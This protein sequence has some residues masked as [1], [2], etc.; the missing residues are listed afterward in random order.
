MS[1][2]PAARDL[3]PWLERLEAQWVRLNAPIAG[4]LNAG[5]SDDAIDELAE[6]YGVVVPLELRTWWGWHDGAGPWP[7]VAAVNTV[8]IGPGGYEFLSLR[9]ALAK[10]EMNRRA[11]TPPDEF[12]WQASWLPFMTQGA[13]RLYVDCHE[14][15]ADQFSPV[16]LVSWE[17]DMPTVA[18]AWS[19]R[20][21]VSLWVWLLES[22]YYWW[23][24]DGGYWDHRPLPEF[25]YWTGLA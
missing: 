23:E 5:L 22:D 12:V 7:G 11:H 24:S 20:H 18:R 1:I 17:T 14:V 8:T 13:Q 15:T 3:I 25:A 16:K 19:L 21:A 2:H 9:Q 6:P 4:L 10:Y